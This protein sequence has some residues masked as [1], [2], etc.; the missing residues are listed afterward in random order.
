LWDRQMKVKCREV[1]PLFN[2]CVIFNTDADS[3][4]GHP[5]PLN[6]PE[7]TFRRSIALYYYTASKQ[8]Y[9]EV[10]STSTIYHARPGDDAA[11]QR[12][13]KR[14]RYEQRLRQWVPPALMR[15]AFAL[16][17]RLRK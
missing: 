5:D 16:Q 1:L 13:A 8:I 11:T 2:R 17:R 12:E 3:F 14:L 9:N 7:G 4:H 6:T 10:P 15:Y